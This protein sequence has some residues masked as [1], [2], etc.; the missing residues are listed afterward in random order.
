MCKVQFI[1]SNKITFIG[2]DNE[3]TTSSSHPVFTDSDPEAF[4]K[5]FLHCFMDDYPFETP[6][7]SFYS[8]TLYECITVTR[9]SPGTGHPAG[10]TV[11]CEV[12]I[13]PKCA[14]YKLRIN[15][16][17]KDTTVLYCATS[18]TTFASISA[19]IEP[20]FSASGNYNHL[21]YIIPKDAPLSTLNFTATGEYIEI[22]YVADVVTTKIFNHGICEVKC[23]YSDEYLCLN[24]TIPAT[25]KNASQT[26]TV[27]KI[28]AD[29]C[30][31]AL[32]DIDIFEFILLNLRKIEYGFIVEGD[33]MKLNF[34]SYPLKFTII[35]TVQIIVSPEK[36]L[37]ISFEEKLHK[38]EEHMT[39][40]IAAL[41]LSH[42][43]KMH[44]LEEHMKQ[45]IME[46]LEE[47]TALSH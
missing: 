42:E 10:Q 46:A 45:E 13:K 3:I 23:T 7:K 44:A 5:L 34:C 32:C 27:T 22:D 24:V 37:L 16:M 31:Y 26:Y 4:T 19:D 20:I 17:E 36:L 21:G 14:I 28:R 41:K 29:Y 6:T 43:E 30:H 47:F 8:K 1:N 9:I 38:I 39:R 15:N 12:N 33:K 40:E 11:I 35:L 25:K 2:R 18:I